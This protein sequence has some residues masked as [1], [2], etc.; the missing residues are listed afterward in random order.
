VILTNPITG[1]PYVAVYGGFI[2]WIF[3]GTTYGVSIRDFALLN[4]DT[5]SWTNKGTPTFD[6]VIS[7][8][9]YNDSTCCT[10]CAACPSSRAE[11]AGEFV[12]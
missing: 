1:V 11:G 4:L 3:S 6:F 9:G 7:T 8:F 10:G 5:L 2:N 12:Y